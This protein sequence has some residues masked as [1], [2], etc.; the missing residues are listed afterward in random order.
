MRQDVGNEIQV[1][2]VRA[3]CSS[4]SAARNAHPR[5]GLHA[6]RN[7]NFDGVGTAYAAFATA[8][9]AEISNSPRAATTGASQIE[10]HLPA[11]LRHLSCATAS[12]AGLG[13]SNCSA[14]MTFG[15]C[16]EARDREL[17]HCAVHCLPES[18]F[19]L[20]FEA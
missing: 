14:A 2:R 11:S 4:I 6:C 3:R 20:I 8:D 1:A 5:T 10:A 7:S 9:P 13:L 19:D 17:L 15:A 18:D 12:C 16:I